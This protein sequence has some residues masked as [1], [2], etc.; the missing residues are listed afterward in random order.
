MHDNFD[1]IE[2]YFTGRCTEAEKQQFEDR[3]VLDQNFAEEVAFY[4]QSRQ[5]LKEELLKQKKS[6]WSPAGSPKRRPGRLPVRG[7]GRELDPVYSGLQ[8]TLSGHAGNAS[9]GLHPIQAVSRAIAGNW[10][11][12]PA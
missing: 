7:G 11:P 3:I 5:I 9:A 1:Y 6:Q 4:I 10:P 2:T 8:T 12:H